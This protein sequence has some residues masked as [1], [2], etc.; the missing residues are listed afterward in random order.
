[1]NEHTLV[2]G[3]APPL[4]AWTPQESEKSPER[5]PRSGPQQS[6]KSA[7]R[8]LQRVQK[9]LKSVGTLEHQK[10]TQS[11]SLA[12]S[13]LTEPNRQKSRRKK[14]FGAQSLTEIAARNR[15]SLVTFHRTLKSQCSIA[16]SCLGNRAISGVRDGHRNRKSQKSL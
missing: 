8:S 14:G 12:I 5:V 4:R 7:P 10:I 2:S 3:L 15:K 6:H 16:F 11:Q 13:A 1:M 9:G